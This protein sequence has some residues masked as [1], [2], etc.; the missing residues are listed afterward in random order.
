MGTINTYSRLHCLNWV[1]KV[2]VSSG[3]GSCWEVGD[4]ACILDRGRAPV[5]H[6]NQHLHLG[7]E[8][9]SSIDNFRLQVD[10]VMVGLAKCFWCTRYIT[11]HDEYNAQSSH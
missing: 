6:S 8:L 7:A 10:T 4:Q 3:G 2:V 9:V 11:S 5:G 1:Q